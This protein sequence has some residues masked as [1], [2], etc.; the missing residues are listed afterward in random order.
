MSRFLS[1]VSVS[2]LQRDAMSIVERLE[3]STQPTAVT[4]DKRPRAILMSLEAFERSE[5]ERRL[6][7]RLALGEAEIEA[8]VGHGLDEVLAE[9]D[10]ILR[11]NEH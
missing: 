1:T 7:K 6:L 9:A 5:D 11:S 8:G 3:G 10:R 4:E 2:D